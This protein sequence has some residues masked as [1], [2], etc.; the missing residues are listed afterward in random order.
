MQLS[1]WA[2]W[3]MGHREQRWAHS[4][5]LLGPYSRQIWKGDLFSVFAIPSSGKSFPSAKAGLPELRGNSKSIY[6]SFVFDLLPDELVLTQGVAGLSR[7]G[8]DRS[9]LHLLLDGT[10]QGEEGLPSTLL[11]ERRI[12][13]LEFRDPRYAGLTL[14]SLLSWSQLLLGS[15]SPFP[16]LCSAGLHGFLPCGPR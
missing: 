5:H 16:L 15:L 10:E 1:L 11:H 8:V 9:L 14:L 7:D 12:P 6:Q 13:V 2:P 3:C 4:G